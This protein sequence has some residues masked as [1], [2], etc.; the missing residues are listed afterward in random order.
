MADGR[1]EGAEK[2]AEVLQI[3]EGGIRQKVKRWR[4][5]ARQ[6]E[7]FGKGKVMFWARKTATNYSQ[8]GINKGAFQARSEK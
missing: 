1:A 2:R 6:V 4:K 8:L 7:V 5:E 3:T